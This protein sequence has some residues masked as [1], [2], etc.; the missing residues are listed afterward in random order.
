MITSLIAS[1]FLYISL[2]WLVVRRMRRLTQSMMSFRDKPE[3]AAIIAPSGADDEIGLAQRELARMQKTVLGALR[4]NERLVALGT[5]V[6]KISHD[7]KNILSTVR[8]HVG[9]AGGQRSA[10][11]ETRDA[12]A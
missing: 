9:R 12:E 5:T 11:G 4:Q 2:Q 6:T 1:V 3:E 8:L 10:R 7:L